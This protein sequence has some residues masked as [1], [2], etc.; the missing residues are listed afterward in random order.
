MSAVSRLPA[1]S[2]RK[3]SRSAKCRCS[4]PLATPASAVIARVVNPAG[5]PDL[6]E[7]VRRIVAALMAGM[8]PNPE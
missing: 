2:A 4:T 1:N 3:A 6:P 5:L 8:G 7:R